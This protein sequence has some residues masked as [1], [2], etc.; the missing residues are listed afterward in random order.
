MDRNR[1]LEIIQGKN[2]MGEMIFRRA[3]DDDMPDIMKLQYSI[4]NG[5]QGIP[6]ELIDG[7]TTVDNICWC[8]EK[9]GEII[10]AA[11]AWKENDEIHWGRFVVIP[12]LRGQG[13]GTELAGYSFGELFDEGA[14][15]IYMEARDTTVEIVC[16]MGGKVTGEPFGFF[17]GDVTPVELK[18]EDLIR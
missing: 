16:G 12:S 2:N 5:E 17:I 13:I 9:D 8:V 11:A 7:F 10:G 1:L 14:E 3:S 6:E 15:I 4:F 18:K